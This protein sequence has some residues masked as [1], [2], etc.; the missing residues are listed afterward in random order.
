MATI[1]IIRDDPRRAR[2]HPREASTTKENAEK[3]GH[4]IATIIR[5][6]RPRSS[7]T[8]RLEDSLR[9]ELLERQAEVAARIRVFE[10]SV[11]VQTRRPRRKVTNGKP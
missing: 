5:L 2:G 8:D 3:R 1:G 7:E 4:V 9:V 11:V 10:D 6:L